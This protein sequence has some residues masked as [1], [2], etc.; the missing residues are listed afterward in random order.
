M[1]ISTKSEID[2]RINSHLED[3]NFDVLVDEKQ[4][5]HYFQKLMELSPR[6]AGSVQLE[7]CRDYLRKQLS[8]FSLSVS[9]EPFHAY[10]SDGKMAMCNVI[11]EKAGKSDQ[12]ILLGSHIDTKIMPGFLVVGA[13]DSTSSTAA[14]LELARIISSQDTRYTYRFVFFDGEESFEEHMTLN[15][16]L[17]GSKYHAEQLHQQ[18]RIM[19]VRALI[20][21][22]MI[23][24]KNLTITQDSNSSPELYELL[25]S[26][27]NRL[28]YSDI[29]KGTKMSVLDDHIPFRDIGIPVLDIIDFE[30]GPDN[31]LWHTRHDVAENVSLKNIAR[32]TEVVICMLEYLEKT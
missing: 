1:P 20:L 29:T 8:S 24:D 28:G 3:V 25:V 19:D 18:D 31:S 12:I 9:D 4:I 14:L 22:D 2:N 10:S 27:C 16:G 30:F 32:V 26:C 7:K 17:Y 13:N 23:G 15:D 11:A 5:A 6:Q 21:L